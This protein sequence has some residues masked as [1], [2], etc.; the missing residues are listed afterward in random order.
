MHM[1]PVELLWKSDQPV[2]EAATYSTY[3][4]QEGWLSTPS[5]GFETLIQTS[6]WELTYALDRTGTRTSIY[7]LKKQ[8]NSWLP[9]IVSRRH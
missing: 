5:A 8:N 4:K 3:N 1:H 7:V 2:A 6:E 9:A